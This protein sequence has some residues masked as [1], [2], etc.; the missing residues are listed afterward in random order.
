MKKLFNDTVALVIERAGLR[1]KIVGEPCV[2]VNIVRTG[3]GC[4]E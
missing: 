4:V 2:L 3:N 1:K